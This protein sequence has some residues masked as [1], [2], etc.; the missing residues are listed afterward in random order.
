MNYFLLKI[1]KGNSE[2][3]DWL[4]GRR[5]NPFGRPGAVIYFDNL[6]EADYRAGKGSS[7]PRVFFE[8]GADQKSWNETRMVVVCEGVVW[9]LKPAGEVIFMPEIDRPDKTRCTPKAMPVDVLA[10]C[11]M[12]DVPPVLACIGVNQFYV[13]GTFRRINHW[14]NFKAIDQTVGA[15]CTGEHW[16]LAKQG[17]TQLLE[18]LGSVEFE[19]LIAK[20]LEARGFF[21]PAYRGG[22]IQHIDL[23]AHNDTDA[24]LDLE[25][26][27]ILARQAAS[28]QV[29]TWSNG[30]AKTEAVDYLIGFDVKGAGTFNSEWVLKQVLDCHSAA[31]WL[32]RSLNWLP[33]ELLL[34]FQLN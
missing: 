3:I 18:C 24:D 27:K 13:R 16:D 17:P 2:A 26:L 15:P 5:P 1:G 12:K 30:K 6:T 20:L 4:E 14:G 34:N 21:V 28:I 29:K 8:I 32:K 22:V 10:R 7:Q 33:R 31:A 19:T 11:P 25:G 23:F 9:V